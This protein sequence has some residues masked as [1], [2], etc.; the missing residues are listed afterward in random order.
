MFRFTPATVSGSQVGMKKDLRYTPA[1]PRGL[2]SAGY[3]LRYNIKFTPSVMGMETRSKSSKFTPVWAMNKNND[4]DTEFEGFTLDW[5]TDTAIFNYDALLVSAFYGLDHPD[6]REYYGIPRDNFIFVGDSGGYQIWTQKV[7]IEPTDILRWQEN[8]VDIGLTLDVPPPSPVVN[9]KD[10]EYA[11]KQ[12]YRNSE[13]M[14]RNRQSED[15][16]MYKVIQGDNQKEMD[17]WWDVMSDLEFDGISIAPRPP[18]AEKMAIGLGFAMSKGVKNIHVLLGTGGGTIPTIIYAR[19]YFDLLTVDSSS[20]SSAG[21]I[22]RS[23]YLPFNISQTLA[24]GKQFNG[25]LKEL[26]C[27]CPVC[28]VSSVKDMNLTKNDQDTGGRSMAS[29][30]GGLIALHNLYM[31]LRHHHFLEKLSDDRENFISYLRTQGLD[32]AIA[33]IEF[34]DSVNE[35]GFEDVYKEKY[36]HESFNDWWA[37]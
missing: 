10:F 4:P 25:E 6:F 32:E 27:D 3:T 35:R 22:Y 2:S 21:A 24:F 8:N 37:Q 18:N 33:G 26:P 11:A 30:S 7:Q 13:I 20:F 16:L 14:H 34:L 9:W 29:I 23:Y 12:T 36:E 19:K 15:I 17:Y 1:L 31:V 28:Q 5:W